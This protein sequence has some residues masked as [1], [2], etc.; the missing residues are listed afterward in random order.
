MPI[1]CVGRVRSV[2]SSAHF[3]FVAIVR[4]DAA[5]LHLEITLTAAAARVEHL[6]QLRVSGP[7][8]PSDASWSRPPRN[9][10]APRVVFIGDMALT[11]VLPYLRGV[12][13]VPVLLL[14]SPEDDRAGGGLVSVMRRTMSRWGGAVAMSALLISPPTADADPPVHEVQI[15]ASKFMFEPSTIDVRAG[16]AVRLVVRSK[17]GAH[18]FSIPKLKIDVHLPKTG[19]S[20]TVEFMAPPPG[21]YEVACSE[22]CGSGHGQMKA[23]LVSA[24]STL[25]NR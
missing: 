2:Q 23:A 9:K 4:T 20:V 13:H 21:R 11:A 19:D 22:F 15:V 5:E 3:A 6:F 24:A 12:W 8:R 14:H 7:T 10:P 18:G 1:S 17:E 16:E 25:T